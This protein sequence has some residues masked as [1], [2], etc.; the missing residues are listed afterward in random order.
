MIRNVK[1]KKLNNDS[2]KTAYVEFTR[3]SFFWT[4]VTKY[5]L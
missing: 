1:K 2:E 3:E 5:T 4:E